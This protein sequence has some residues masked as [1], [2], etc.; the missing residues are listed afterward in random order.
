M[1]LSILIEVIIYFLSLSLL[2]I[3]NSHKKSLKVKSFE[4][5]PDLF[6]DE[7]FLEGN[8]IFSDI[9]SQ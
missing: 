2:I 3:R 7:N 9:F 1:L 4:L 5:L 8:C 6:L